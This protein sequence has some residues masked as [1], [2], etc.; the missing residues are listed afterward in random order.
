[1]SKLP[2]AEGGAPL[3]LEADGDRNGTFESLQGATVEPGVPMRV[4]SRGGSPA[5]FIRVRANGRTI[6]RAAS[7]GTVTFRAPARTG[8]VRAS[9]LAAPGEAATTAPGCAPSGQSVSTCAYDQQL[10]ALT[11]PLYVR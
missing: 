7:G 5:G 11:S 10:L 2:P 6:V 4:R 8:W 1:V 3:L 9:L